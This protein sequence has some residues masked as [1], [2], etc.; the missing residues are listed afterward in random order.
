MNRLK[1]K[2]P[3]DLWIFPVIFLVLMMLGC[4]TTKTL[5][6]D[7]LAYK[8]RTISSTNEDVTVTVAVPT[9]SEAQA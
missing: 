7:L 1:L 6:V 3:R 2:T 5:P 8:N 9:I 4:A